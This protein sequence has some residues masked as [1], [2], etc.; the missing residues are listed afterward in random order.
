MVSLYPG[1]NEEKRWT[2]A[3]SDKLIREHAR[4]GIYM[5]GG[6]GA[7]YRTFYAINAFL[8][9]KNRMSQAEQLRLFIKGLS[10]DLWHK[11]FTRLSIKEPDHDPNDFWLLEDVRKAGEYVLNGT[12]LP[13]LPMGVGISSNPSFSSG[14]AAGAN[15]VSENVVKK[16]ELAGMFEKF[17]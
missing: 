6:F 1:E 11:I 14:L 17:T 16:E 4:M 7:Y 2:L 9:Q 5:I 13:V 10:T 15:N 8:L 3:D 12:N